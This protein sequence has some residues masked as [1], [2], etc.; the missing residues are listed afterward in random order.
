M[1]RNAALVVAA[2]A[3]ADLVEVVGALCWIATAAH[4]LGDSQRRDEAVHAAGEVA[5]DRRLVDFTDPA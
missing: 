5:R 2:D 4:F 3:P 1:T